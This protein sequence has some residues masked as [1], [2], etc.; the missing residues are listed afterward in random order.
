[1]KKNIFMKRTAIILAGGKSSRMGEDKGLML[2]EGKTMIQ[3]IIDTIQPLVDDVIIISNQ[4]GYGIF[5]FP[6][7][8]ILFEILFRSF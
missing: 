5:G 6:V 4:T 1:M 2:F 8:L 7:Y 3:Y